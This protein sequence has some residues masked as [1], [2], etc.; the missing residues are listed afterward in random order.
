MHTDKTSVAM[1]PKQ[2]DMTGRKVNRM[3]KVAG[4]TISKLLDAFHFPAVTRKLFLLLY[5]KERL[6]L[7]ASG[8]S[9]LVFVTSCQVKSTQWL[10][11]SSR[12]IDVFHETTWL[13][14][15]RDKCCSLQDTQQIRYRFY[16]NNRE[17]WFIF[18]RDSCCRYPI[19]V[20]CASASL[21]WSIHFQKPKWNKNFSPQQQG[22]LLGQSSP[23]MLRWRD[24]ISERIWNQAVWL[25]QR[26]G[27]LLA[28]GKLH[29]LQWQRL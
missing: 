27:I 19:T 20:H 3:K 4:Q 10:R 29:C 13:Y 17:R 7:T 5:R 28:R 24:Q 21:T 16:A 26:Y 25:L 14:M 11:L 6:S 18:T 1:W 9:L 12:Q 23:A 2:S 15:F 8:S 22:R